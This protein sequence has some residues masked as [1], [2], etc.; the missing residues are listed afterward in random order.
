MSDRPDFAV[1][2]PT[3]HISYEQRQVGVTL[4]DAVRRHLRPG[5]PGMGTTGIGPLRVWYHDL[6]TPELPANPLAGYVVGA[7]G[8]RLASGWSGPVA[9]S[10]E[11]D[12]ATEQVPPMTPEVQDAFNELRGT[13]GG[14]SD[15]HLH[16]GGN[17]MIDLDAPHIHWIRNGEHTDLYIHEL[18]R[19]WT[20][21][22]LALG[23]VEPGRDLPADSEQLFSSDE[24]EEAL[25]F[26][27]DWL[28]ARLG[29]SREATEVVEAVAHP[30]I[31]AATLDHML[32]SDD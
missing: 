4:N 3:G 1:L 2:H 29:A 13:T 30:R 18:S 32:C 20:R 6:F 23:A 8:Y 16:T 25:D 15:P 31:K 12:R 28:E 14:L 26:Y 19:R 27:R 24:V 7:F 5:R 10:M 21:V 17:R 9:V 11:E 22:D